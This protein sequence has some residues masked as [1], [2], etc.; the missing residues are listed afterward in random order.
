[1]RFNKVK[2]RVLPSGHTNPMQRCRLGDEW[3]ERCSAEKDLGVLV[4]SQLNVS[5]QCP[6]WPRRPT[7]SWLVSGTVWP[8]GVGR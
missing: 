8:G 3:L 6:R 1:M 5:Q 4:D 2:C 7:A